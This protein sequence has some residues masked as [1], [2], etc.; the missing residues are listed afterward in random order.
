M[1][2]FFV[3]ACTLSL[4]CHIHIS[5]SHADPAAPV[6]GCSSPDGP[7]HGVA[8]TGGVGGG[9]EGVGYGTTLAGEMEGH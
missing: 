3:Y 9:G 5:G 6:A 4:S 2:Y 8:E 7:L 1:L